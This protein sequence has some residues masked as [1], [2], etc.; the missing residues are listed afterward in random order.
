MEQVELYFL[1]NK[2][3]DSLRAVLLTTVGSSNYELLRN[4]VATVSPEYKLYEEIV[5]A[6]TSPKAALHS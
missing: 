3:E 1:G 5:C 2:I 6:L 4:L